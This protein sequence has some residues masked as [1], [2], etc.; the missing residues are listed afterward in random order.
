MTLYTN[1]NKFPMPHYLN[2]LYPDYLGKVN[3]TDEQLEAAI[4]IY[5][6]RTEANNRLHPSPKYEDLVKRFENTRLTF[7]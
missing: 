5:K 1:G 4:K 3:L 7:V 6:M 2:G